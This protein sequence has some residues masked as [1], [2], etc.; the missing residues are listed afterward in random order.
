MQAE[1]GI[2]DALNQVAASNVLSVG[3]VMFA[4]FLVIGLLLWRLVPPL[5]HLGQTVLNKLSRNVEELTD[6]L[7]KAA[8]AQTESHQH[9]AEA[10]QALA[11]ATQEIQGATTRTERK[12]D[13]AAESRETHNE[14][15][16]QAIHTIIDSLRRIEALTN[17]SF[18]ASKEAASAS[19]DLTRYHDNQIEQITAIRQQVATM[20]QR[21][22]EQESKE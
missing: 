14:A 17:Q 10:I 7:S 20:A 8:T 1:A 4:V 12:I 22:A 2:I 3:G 15:M 18:E 5:V 6:S 13:A 21:H 19:R 9:M 11:Q 16:Q